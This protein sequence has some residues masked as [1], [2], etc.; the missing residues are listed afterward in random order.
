[1]HTFLRL[2]A[3]S[4]ESAKTLG[5]HWRLAALAWLPAVSVVGMSTVLARWLS[6][7][8]CLLGEDLE[9][10]ADLVACLMEEVEEVAEEEEIEEEESWDLLSWLTV[11]VIELTEG[12][13]FICRMLEMPVLALVF[14]LVDT[15]LAKL[16]PIISEVGV[17]V[18]RVFDGSH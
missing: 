15:S 12:E 7:A 6:M 8:E 11:T 13:R 1:M 4:A 16:L 10:E 3:A 17:L 9:A 5:W 18:S 14:S 2:V